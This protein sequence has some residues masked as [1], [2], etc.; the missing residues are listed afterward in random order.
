MAGTG[1]R[2]HRLRATQSL[3]RF[4]PFTAESAEIAGQWL[5]DERNYK[6]L[7]FGGGRQKLNGRMLHHL[8]RS[9]D[10][11]IRSMVDDDGRQIG[12]IGLQ[13]VSSPFC[14]AM[15]W[16]VRPRLRPPSHALGWMEIKEFVGIG[17]REL[18]L[19]S[20]YAWVVE[21]N[22]LSLAVLQ[23][24]GFRTMGRQRRAHMVDGVLHD[25]ILLD[26]LA[27]EHEPHS[28]GLD[29]Q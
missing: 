4:I 14:N 1:M 5:M 18:K 16:G 28:P 11:F 9:S 22:R 29:V 13:H 15:L 6:W 17:F 26:T 20:V 7:D 2:R 27:S 3:A 24:A 10:N 12:V 23:R 21:T 8:A 25:R 19:Q